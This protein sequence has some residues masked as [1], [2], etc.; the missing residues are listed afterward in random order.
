MTC[1]RVPL[2]L[3]LTLSLKG[4]GT[5]LAQLETMASA[6]TN[7][8]LSLRSG[9]RSQGWGERAKPRSQTCTQNNKTGP[10]PAEEPVRRNDGMHR[11]GHPNRTPDCMTWSGR[12]NANALGETR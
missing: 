11:R 10:A 12:Q 9:A 1:Q 6:G 3:S 2:A 5:G 7:N 4:E 8:A